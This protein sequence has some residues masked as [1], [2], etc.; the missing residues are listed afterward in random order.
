M[1]NRGFTMLEMMVVIAVIAILGLIAL[2]SYQSRI[3]RQQIEAAWPLA[4]I[5]KKPIAAS[6]GATHTFLP[7]N[8]AAGLP[9][10]DKMVNNYVSAVAVQDGAI[11]ITFGNRASSVIAGKILSIR[12][13]VVADAPIVPVTWVCGKADPPQKMTVNGVDR[14]SVPAA[15][16]PLECRKIGP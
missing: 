1:K 12:P 6:W 14:T 5:A 2:P 7:D 4:D 10:P 15:V 11:N 9:A 13:A 8:A 16:L 3:V